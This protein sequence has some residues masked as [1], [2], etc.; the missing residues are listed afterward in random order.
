MKRLKI[1]IIIPTLN[2]EV[3]LP[4]LL[5]SIRQQSFS[6]YEV[7][8][9]DAGSTDRTVAI[10]RKLG[11]QVV[12]GGKPGVARNNGAKMARGDFFYFLDA[13][14]VLPKYFLKKSWQEIDERFLELA[15]CEF[16]PISEYVID[17]LL[18]NIVNAYIAMSQFRE[19]LAGGACII[20][21]RRLFN[22][23]KGFNEKLVMA[24]D[25]DFIARAAK[26]RK[27][28]LL[29]TTKINISVRRL[30]KEGRLVITQK[31]LQS[32]IYKALHGQIDQ[33]IYNY[34]FGDFSSKKISK[35]ERQLL[36]ADKNMRKILDDAKKRLGKNENSR[37]W[38]LSLDRL[39]VSYRDN[40]DKLIRLFD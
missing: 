10:A 20:V 24:E 11:A 14:V 9:A 7:I 23:V 26:F 5:E 36:Q 40:L 22:R 18:H 37:Q 39:V 4:K 35:Q 3:L 27:F 8:V 25:H 19:P 33:E 1:S 21:G 32:E 30:D 15:S 6:D 29:L 13:D 34:Q 38:E 16:V 12:K 31:Y 2:E 28:R 17:H